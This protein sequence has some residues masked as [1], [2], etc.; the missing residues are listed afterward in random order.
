MFDSDVN[1][2]VSYRLDVTAGVLSTR[3]TVPAPERGQELGFAVNRA[4]RSGPLRCRQFT[5]LRSFVMVVA[6]LA[7]RP[8]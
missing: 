1:L 7:V 8:H 3:A 4:R 6:V 2:G 5:I